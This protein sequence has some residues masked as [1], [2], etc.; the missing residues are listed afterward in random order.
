MNT[1]NQDAKKRATAFALALK[2][3]DA[4]EFQECQ[5]DM[6]KL[7][8]LDPEA[9]KLVTAAIRAKQIPVLARESGLDE[10]LV[11]SL[12]S[13]QPQPTMDF[14]NKKK[15]EPKEEEFPEAEEHEEMPEVEEHKEFPE[16]EME[17]PDKLE[18]LHDE[19]EMNKP[20]EM[21]NK[22]EDSEADD[23]DE[24]MA[25]INLQVPMNMVESVKKA[26]ENL[27]TNEFADDSS[28]PDETGFPKQDFETPDE[29]DEDEIEEKSNFGDETEDTPVKELPFKNDF[30]ESEEEPRSEKMDIEASNQNKRTVDAS[31]AELLAKRR[32]YRE[33]L[34]TRI[35]E[36]VKPKDI[37]LGD[38]TSHGGK[39]FQYSEKN[40]HRG[41]VEYP[42]LTLDDSGGNSLAGDPGYAK[43][44]IPTKNFET[45]QLKDSYE[46][47]KFSGG[48]DGT[49]DFSVD[50]NEMLKIPSAGESAT[51]QKFE[52]PTQQNLSKH[53]TTIAK[54]VTC[55]GCDNPDDSGV[56]FVECQDCGTR[57]ALCNH[58][59]GEE[60]CP[61]CAIKTACDDKACNKKYKK[62]DNEK[63]EVES[64]GKPTA[65]FQKIDVIKNINPNTIDPNN[66]DSK[67]SSDDEEKS[68]KEAEV[69]KAR[70]KTAFA[71]AAQLALANVIGA[72][73]VNDQVELWMNDGMSARSIKA[74]SAVM[75]R[76]AQNSTQRVV[77]AATNESSVR[78]A[79][80]GRISTN[81]T[82]VV[83][84]T[85]TNSDLKDTIQSILMERFEEE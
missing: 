57:L 32:A 59:L 47:F 30:Q 10:S 13:P 29:D 53:K 65:E 43:A 39:P 79:S 27:F 38:D 49:L 19:H 83:S 50:F 45:L 9:A 56:E 76:C 3:T 51:D 85:T 37:N 18:G 46:D 2:A 20:E 31:T 36:D 40:Q 70:L 5:K 58:C 77:S 1:K 64:Q 84:N 60:Y 68:K 48:D 16:E 52:V 54:V 80:A 41:E 78:T 7:A 22:D 14:A 17:E 11:Q 4:E 25:N 15:I 55:M 23:E 62:D 73:E 42:K 63:K 81:P 6:Q 44:T 71:A 21:F 72:D 69:Y 24:Q 8:Q 28:A 82:F 66:I 75:L 12:I 33:N 74:Q 67:F 26:L 34:L 61:T 35:A